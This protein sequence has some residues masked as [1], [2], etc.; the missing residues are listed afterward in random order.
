MLRVE[1]LVKSFDGF[2]AVNGA[3]LTV[4]EKQIVAVIGPNGAGKTTLFNLITGHLVPTGGKVIFKDR[5]ITGMAPHRICHLGISRSFQLI[6]V[7]PQL[8]VFENVQV[9]VLSHQ[10]KV[11]NMFAPAQKLVVEETYNILEKVRLADKAREK[12][13][14]LSYGDQKI[15]EMA[16]ALG[17]YPELLMLDEPTAGMSPEETKATIALVQELAKKEGLTVLFTEHNMNVVFE[18]SEKIM[19]MQQGRTIAQDLPDMVRANKQ[20]QAAYLGEES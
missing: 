13:A 15:L 3:N 6:N 9:S 12:T 17:N 20:V 19:V 14:S 11:L 4:H 1:N 2:L 5:E 18:I 16:I 10:K 7:F 8:S